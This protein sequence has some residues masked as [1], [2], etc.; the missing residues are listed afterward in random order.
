MARSI[1]NPQNALDRA[2]ERPSRHCRSRRRSSGRRS[3][4][5]RIS[6]GIAVLTLNRPQ[7]RNSLSEAMLRGARRC[8]DRDR[9]RARGARGRARRERS[10][11]LRRPRS[12]GAQRAPLRRGSRPRLFQA[13]HGAVQRRDAADRHAAAAGDRR[14]PG[15]R[16][17]GGLPAG[18]ELRSRRRLARREIRDAGVNIG[19]FCST[20]MVALSRNVSRKARDGNAADRRDDLGRG[21][22]AHRPRQSRGRARQ[23]ARRSAQARRKRSPPN[24]R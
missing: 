19:L 3:C 7:A 12:Q 23:R 10:G 11:L 22:R 16:D 21:R 6:R 13:H 8:A 5:A 1:A 2:D 18:G 15:H 24:R 17:G 4:C 14:G 20:P 9:A